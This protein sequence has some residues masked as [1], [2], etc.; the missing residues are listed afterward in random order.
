MTD[1][2]TIRRLQADNAALSAALQEAE[3]ALDMVCAPT[4]QFGTRRYCMQVREKIGWHLLSGGARFLELL[5]AARVVSAFG[6][7]GTEMDEA[8]IALRQT[9]AAIDKEGTDGR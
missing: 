6:L 7:V 4:Y 8:L 3:K 5:Q 9:V 2:E 1:R